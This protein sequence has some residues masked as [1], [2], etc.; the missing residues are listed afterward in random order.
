MKGW[1][2]AGSSIDVAPARPLPLP[3]ERGRWRVRLRLCRLGPLVL[4]GG[5]HSC[6]G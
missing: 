2:G 5:R 3:L 1:I 4:A 6:S